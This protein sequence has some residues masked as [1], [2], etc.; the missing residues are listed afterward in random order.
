M[1]KLLAILL[2]LIMCLTLFP[3]TIFAASSNSIKVAG[4]ANGDGQLNGADLVRIRKYLAGISG[5]IDQAC[6]DVNGDGKVN[7]GDLVR[8]RKY[9]A[10]QD[11]ELVPPII[12]PDDVID[13]EDTI[14]TKDDHY[15]LYSEEK[16]AIANSGEP[17]HF[18]VNTNL[19][20]P[21][22]ELYMDGKI[23]EI[24][25]LDNGETDDDIP[26]DGCYS[27]VYYVNSPEEKDVEFVAK[28]KV[29]NQIIE[30]NSVSIFFYFELT[31][32]QSERLD[33]ID[34]KVLQII[35]E[36]KNNKDSKSKEEVKSTIEKNLKA[37]LQE[38]KESSVI[39]D[40][41]YD[42]EG[43]LFT[44]KDKETGIAS[45]ALFDD[46]FNDSNIK[47]SE[48]ENEQTSKLNESAINV[49]YSKG[50]T[51]V[52][53]SFNSDAWE[54]DTYDAVA[55][56]LRGANFSCDSKYS[57]T[58]DNFKY[59]K[60]YN[61]LIV[62]NSHGNTYNGYSSGSKKANPCICTN[63]ESTYANKKSYSSDLKKNR[64]YKV[65]KKYWIA[66]S[67]ITFWYEEHK[68]H[69]PI[70]YL[71]NCRNY[72]NDQMVKAWYGAGAESVFGY[73]A[74][75]SFDYDGQMVTTLVDQLLSGESVSKALSIAKKK[76]GKEDSYYDD[77][78]EMYAVLKLYGSDSKNLYHGL[79]NGLFD[80]SI[81]VELNDLHNWEIYGDCRSIYKLSGIQPKSLP[82]MAIVSSGF[83]SM[84]G[85]TTSCMYQTVLVPNNAS[86]L[87]FIYDVV[88][89]E[90]ME[91]VG[92]QFDDIF[93]VDIL[94]P[95]GLVLDNLAYESVNTSEW[96]A[97]DGIDFPNGDH[98]TYHTRWKT[99]T[100][101]GIS[102]YRGQLI[103]LRFT[104]QDSGDS[105][106][107]TAALVDSV[108]IA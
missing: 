104:V 106:Y 32:E 40:L 9:M 21:Y 23:T 75:V 36:A 100:S 55:E 96:F 63:E 26:N 108:K 38:L 107:D 25:L 3:V 90:P 57:F 12:E 80:S 54:N 71:G 4:D 69:S 81:S 79:D 85:E 89:E 86:S 19:T 58:V 99:V 7:G 103:V 65:N 17:I 74:S 91:Y 48:S 27:G 105:I 10:G 61:S 37:Y 6:S 102:K 67:F 50:K 41:Y 82:K 59:L 97:V 72:G 76:H 73:T 29:G 30:T 64:I 24:K 8:L 98:T 14:V 84:N 34:N 68:L 31:E 92:T 5:E 77:S 101:E 70:V 53:N 66:P 62:V 42:K 43:S 95:D 88:S 78:W 1:K 15:Y 44:W 11:V 22:F 35:E 2:A 39:V 33:E 47:A 94:N 46:P 16:E 56:K 28:A 93:S 20:I 13:E 45:G 18:H 60:G 87:S 51:I 49:S 83:G 52:L